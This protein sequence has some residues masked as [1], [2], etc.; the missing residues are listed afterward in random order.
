M[1]FYFEI[2]RVIANALLKAGINPAFLSSSAQHE[3]LS[4]HV[5]PDR[6]LYSRS[7]HKLLLSH[8]SN[9]VI[10]GIPI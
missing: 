5:A 9:A 2:I 7:L 8:H 6:Y 4:A 10:S 1:L 3:L